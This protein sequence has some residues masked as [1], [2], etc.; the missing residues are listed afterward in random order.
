[1]TL[2]VFKPE[3]FPTRSRDALFVELWAQKKPHRSEVVFCEPDWI[4]TNDLPGLTA[5]ML[6]PTELPAQKQALLTCFCVIRIGISSNL[7]KRDLKQLYKIK[8]LI[9]NKLVSF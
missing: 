2:S 5:G 6:Y 4:R 7:L 3:T 9:I 8:L 1:M